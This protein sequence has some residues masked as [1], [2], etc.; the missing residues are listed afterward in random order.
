VTLVTLPATAAAGVVK[1]EDKVNPP[2]PA[3]FAP[4][5]LQNSQILLRNLLSVLRTDHW[6]TIGE[7]TRVEERVKGREVDEMG[8]GIMISI[9]WWPSSA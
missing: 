8:E 3:I 9:A 1:V 4:P 2:V 5:G 6:R 7:G